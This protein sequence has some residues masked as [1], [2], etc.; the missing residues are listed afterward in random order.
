M[1]GSIGEDEDGNAKAHSQDACA[2]L[3]PAVRS[4]SSVRGAE[5][6]RSVLLAHLRRSDIRNAEAQHPRPD[7]DRRAAHPNG[8]TYSPKEKPWYL[9]RAVRYAETSPSWRGEWPNQARTG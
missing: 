8:L 2:D 5:A 3:V 1:L 7:V 6:R 9:C 4:A